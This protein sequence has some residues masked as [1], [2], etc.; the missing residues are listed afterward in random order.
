MA[1]SPLFARWSAARLRQRGTPDPTGAEPEVTDLADPLPLPG[2][3]VVPDD[4]VSPPPM[5]GERRRILAMD[6]RGRGPRGP[7]APPGVPISAS[8]VEEFV[9]DVYTVWRHLTPLWPILDNLEMRIEEVPP[10]QF[11]TVPA[12]LGRNAVGRA[13]WLAIYRRP[14]E[15]AARSRASRRRMIGEA[16]RSVLPLQ[17][18]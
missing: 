1:R 10:P 16:I 15:G 9:L 8:R 14:I 18:N 13:R 17:A 5:S 7:L 2:G 3:V 4:L 11:A 6:P 12:H